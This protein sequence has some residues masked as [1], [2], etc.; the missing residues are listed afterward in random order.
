[1]MMVARRKQ[2]DACNA[3]LSKSSNQREID[4]DKH[5]AR[6]DTHVGKKMSIAPIV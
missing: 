3:N 2:S 1:M 5:K 6:L 4:L